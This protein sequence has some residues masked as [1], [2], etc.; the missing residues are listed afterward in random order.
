MNKHCILFSIII[1]YALVASAAHANTESDQVELYKSSRFALGIG[2]AIVRFDTKL[3]FTD[4]TRSTFNS[5]FLDPEGNLGLPETSS[6]KTFY[7]GWNINRFFV[8]RR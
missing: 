3:K 7:G 1:L 6:V 2:A 5:I 8:F 4:K